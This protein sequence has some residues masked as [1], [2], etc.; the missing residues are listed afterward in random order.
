VLFYHLFC[1]TLVVFR[2][3]DL[4][5]S[6]AYFEGLLG[7]ELPG[8][9]VLETAVVALCVLLHFAERWARPRAAALQR[10]T[11]EHRFGILAEALVFGLITGAVVLASG[12]GGEFI[13]FQF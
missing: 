5:S 13:Y 2:C 8:W 7:N 6:G 11:A 9:P 1:L 12:A 10:F 4:A 3:P